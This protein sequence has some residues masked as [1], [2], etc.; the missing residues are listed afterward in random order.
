MG[1]EETYA[2]KC[3]GP[4]EGSA[5]NGSGKGDCGQGRTPERQEAADVHL[6]QQMAS[7]QRFLS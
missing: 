7:K 1:L 6:H 5:A 3:L 2:W 4:G